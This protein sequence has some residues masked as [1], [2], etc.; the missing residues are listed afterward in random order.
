MEP[1]ADQPHG[2]GQPETLG[3]RVY[4]SS[5]AG[6]LLHAAQAVIE[7]HAELL[8]LRFARPSLEDVF[9]YLTGEYLRS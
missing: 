5:D 9:I 1:V 2:S 4:G 8:D 3:F 6:A 7:E